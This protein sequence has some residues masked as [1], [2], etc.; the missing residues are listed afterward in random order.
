MSPIVS[1]SL[2]WSEAPG[3]SDALAFAAVRQN[4]TGSKYSSAIFYFDE[5][6]EGAMACVA[7]LRALPKLRDELLDLYSG[8]QAKGL[9]P[10]LPQDQRNAERREAKAEAKAEAAAVVETPAPARKSES[11]AS[12]RAG[13]VTTEAVETAT[14]AQSVSEDPFSSLPF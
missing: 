12:K 4:G 8:R 11:M 5:D 3:G 7:L 9:W 2:E 6:V 14:P 13:K 1:Y 10:A